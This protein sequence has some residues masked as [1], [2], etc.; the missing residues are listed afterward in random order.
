MW[1]SSFVGRI[2][3]IVRYP[4]NKTCI[5]MLLRLRNPINKYCWGYWPIFTGIIFD[6]VLVL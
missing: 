4:G 3:D 2:G 1:F 6:G 5:K